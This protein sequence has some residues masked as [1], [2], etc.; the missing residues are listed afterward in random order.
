MNR[1]RMCD[2]ERIDCGGGWEV[3]TERSGKFLMDM[4]RKYENMKTGGE[5]EPKK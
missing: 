3:W 2:E 5:V 4:G 1:K